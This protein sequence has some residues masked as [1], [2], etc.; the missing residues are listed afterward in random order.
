MTDP[1]KSYDVTNYYDN[2]IKN[3]LDEKQGFRTYLSKNRESTCNKTCMEE[4]DSTLHIIC[5]ILYKITLIELCFEHEMEEYREKGTFG[6]EELLDQKI[7]RSI[8]WQLRNIGESF[9]KT[10]KILKALR[11]KCNDYPFSQ[12]SPVRPAIAH[13]CRKHAKRVKDLSKNV[14]PDYIYKSM[15]R[16]YYIKLYNGGGSLEDEVSKFLD[17][18]N[19]LSFEE[20]KEKLTPYLTEIIAAADEKR[21]KNWKIVRLEEYMQQEERK[22]KAKKQRQSEK[23]EQAKIKRKERLSKFCREMEQK[24]YNSRKNQKPH[25]LIMQMA[26]DADFSVGYKDAFIICMLCKPPKGAAYFQYITKN[27]T[28][29]KVRDIDRFFFEDVPEDVIKECYSLPDV[30]AVDTIRIP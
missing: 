25:P 16:P 26:Q 27:G 23:E 10:R 15:L 13:L 5:G 30:V 12:E 11:H 4:I 21:M 29:T 19:A 28:S 2:V 1:C 17:I 7:C 3:I 20:V 22:K 8:Y 6:E 14:L 9:I 18:E 24:L